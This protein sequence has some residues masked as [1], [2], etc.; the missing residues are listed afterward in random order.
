M[1]CVILYIGP[2]SSCLFSYLGLFFPQHRHRIELS[3]VVDLFCT[4]RP[5]ENNQQMFVV[6][7]TVT[8]VTCQFCVY[9]V[10]LI[11]A[12]VCCFQC[13]IEMFIKGIAV[14]NTQYNTHCVYSFA[15]DKRNCSF[16]SR[17]IFTRLC[18]IM[19]LAVNCNEDTHILII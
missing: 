4:P 14:N 9:S 19:Y 8:M 16:N 11:T 6:Y 7:L 3:I 10:L 1:L 17:S 12:V 5:T 15:H 2:V 13:S 18:P